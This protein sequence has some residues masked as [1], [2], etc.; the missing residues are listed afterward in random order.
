MLEL[1]FVDDLTHEV[2]DNSWTVSDSQ[3]GLAPLPGET[4]TLRIGDKKENFKVTGRH[5]NLD[6]KNV[7][8]TGTD[9][10]VKR[11]Y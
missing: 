7:Y 1:R 2:I 6:H 5:W 10:Y 8:D 9:V 4:V 11:I 3:I